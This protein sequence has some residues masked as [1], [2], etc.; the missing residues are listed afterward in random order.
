[1]SEIK[2]PRVG[3]YVVNLEAFEDF[4]K[5]IFSDFVSVENS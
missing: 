5:S 4:V 1:M 3:R 2:G